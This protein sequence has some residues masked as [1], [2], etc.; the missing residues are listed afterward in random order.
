M[1]KISII[2]AIAANGII[3]RNNSLVWHLP[4]DLKHFQKL[5]LD[6]PIIMGRKT[7]E[8]IGKPLPGRRNIVISRDPLRN[9]P[10]CGFY[11]SLNDALAAVNDYP[12]VMIIGGAD[13]Y[14]LALP[15]AE[16]MYLTLVHHKFDGDTCFPKWD[17]TE[18]EE[19]ERQDF[20]ADEKNNYAYS[21]VTLQRAATTE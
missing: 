12:E 21:F 10:D 6:K 5:T 17:Q 19:I 16:K 18:W 20:P 11:A 1:A 15:I 9:C 13:I 7:F 4:A 14:Q 8:A 3:G 2:A